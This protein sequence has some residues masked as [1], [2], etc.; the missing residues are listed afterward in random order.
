MGRQAGSS[1]D[2]E[3]E[4]DK[5]YTRTQRHRGA[6]T[7]LYTVARPVVLCASSHA[8]PCT[9]VACVQRCHTAE[10]TYT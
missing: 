5:E 6:V 8:M 9:P 10:Y 1:L 2:M 3:H 7:S 4:Q